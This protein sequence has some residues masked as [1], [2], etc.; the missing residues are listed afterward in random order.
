MFVVKILIS[1]FIVLMVASVVPELTTKN[2]NG[3]RKSF[4]LCNTRKVK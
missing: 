3:K 4:T 1:L 2:K